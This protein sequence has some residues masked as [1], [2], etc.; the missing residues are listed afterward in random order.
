M[1][2]LVTVPCTI[3]HITILFNV[4][5]TYMLLWSL[6]LIYLY[7][8]MTTAYDLLFTQCFDICTL[9]TGMSVQLKQI[10]VLEFKIFSLSKK[11][12]CDE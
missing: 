3:I 4:L 12:K 2:I 9:F 1:F 10:G 11:S 8:K 7:T 5:N 6:L